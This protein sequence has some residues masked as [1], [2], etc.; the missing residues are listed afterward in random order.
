MEINAQDVIESLLEQNKQ[1]TLQIALLEAALN[2]EQG[3]LSEEE[4]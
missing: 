4:Q 3:V 1:L 2:A